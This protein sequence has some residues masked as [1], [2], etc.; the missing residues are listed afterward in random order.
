M[1]EKHALL[2][3][4]SAGRWL[5]CPPSARINAEMEDTS[6]EYA[7]EGTLAHS[8]CE[9]KLTGYVSA[10]PKR[11]TNSKLNKLKKDKLYQAEMDGYTDDYLNYV[12][13]IAIGLSGAPTVRIEEQVDYSDYA[14]EG[15]GTADCLILYSDELHVIDFKYG[16][17]VEV[18]AEDNPQLKLYALGA[19]KKFAFLYSIK[20]VVLHIVQP[21]IDNFSS[22][23][24][25]ADELRSWGE[26][27]KPIA[28]LAYEGKG[29]FNSGAHCRFCKLSATCR[30]RSEDNLALAQYEFKNPPEFTHDGSPTLTDEEIG[31]VLTLGAQLKKWY[32]DLEK[33][34]LGMILYGKKYD[35]WKAVEGRGTRRFINPDDVPKVLEKMGLSPDLAYEREILSPAKLEKL[36][37]KNDF[38]DNFGGIV[39][40]SK[41]KPTLAPASDKR[42][43]YVS[44]TTA[45]EDF[46][47]EIPKF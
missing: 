28:Q 26:S 17:G 9:I 38:A 21:R 13:E 37:G 8:M 29:N 44:G 27:I 20:K 30:K 2:S 15:F 34:A 12:K 18:S 32:E 24:T 1:P 3:A 6:S 14:P 43:E 41:G 10:I 39:E 23:E 25:S 19:I 35:G 47:E 33:Y 36:I 31:E 42:P 7:A 4:S 40:K 16:R 45:A 11:T 46:S 5:N 22:W